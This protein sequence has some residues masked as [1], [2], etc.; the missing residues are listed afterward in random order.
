VILSTKCSHG[1]MVGPL[2]F[3]QINVSK[4]GVIPKQQWLLIVDLSSF[5]PACVNAGAVLCEYPGCS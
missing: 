3:P 5:K 1:R 2:E 4:F